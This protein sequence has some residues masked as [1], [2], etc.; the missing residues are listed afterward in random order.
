MPAMGNVRKMLSLL[1][2]LVVLQGCESV[3]F[4]QQ[5]ISGQ[6]SLL[7]QRED[8]SDLLATD[9]QPE[10]RQQLELALEILAYA[11]A[12]GLEADG[13][14]SSYVETGRAYVVW[15]VF[16]A[17]PLELSL[18]TSCFPVAGC[19]SYRGYFEK[20]DAERYAEKLRAEGLDVYMG[21]V[22]AYSTLG[23]FD[24]PL[25]DTFLFRPEEYLA[26]LL[27]H[28][29]AHQV[30]YVKGD[31]RFNESLATAIEQHVLE[32]YLRDVGREA[33]FE[34]YLSS[35]ERRAQVLVLINEIRQELRDVYASDLTRNEKLKK[36]E[37]L[38]EQLVGRYD[39]IA[40]NWSE[41]TE[42]RSWVR[43]PMN[44]AKLETVADYHEWVPAMLHQLELRGYEGFVTWLTMLA[45]LS[46]EDRRDQLLK[47]SAAN[48]KP[49]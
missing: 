30:V 38:F 8:I 26:A 4:Y 17:D 45:E 7:W 41:G 27:F 28:E 25:L 47:A 9:I 35:R 49:G 43:G 1:L 34:R 42:Y 36:K 39:E 16:A 3:H 33:A 37:A 22:G 10:L 29:L 31:T 15:N 6:T 14:Y 24:D 11:E 19:V 21:G 44:N 40:K 46:F 2:V 32:Q 23:W 5:A 13:V 48:N 18:K 12:F 20:A